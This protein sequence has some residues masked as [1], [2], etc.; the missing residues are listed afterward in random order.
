M[1]GF[2]KNCKFCAK[3]LSLG[4]NDIDDYSDEKEDLNDFLEEIDDL[5]DLE[6]KYFC[7]LMP[8]EIETEPFNWCGQ[9]RKDD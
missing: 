5:N 6:D 7:K 8:K 9:F 4:M 3:K 1:T 2:C